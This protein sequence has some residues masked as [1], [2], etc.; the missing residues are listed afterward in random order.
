MLCSISVFFASLFIII[1]VILVSAVIIFLFQFPTFRG[2][3]G[4]QAV[5]RA[6]KRYL[7]PENYRIL[8][9]V[10]IC[11]DEGGSTQIDHIVIS[12]YGIFIIETKTMS[13]WIFGDEY[14]AKWMQQI[15]R[16]KNQFQNPL[17]QNYKHIACFSKL[18][19]VPMEG[20]FH[21]I[22]FL[23]TCELKTRDK[24]PASV[25]KGWTGPVKYIKSFKAE[26][27]YREDIPEI[28]AR[29]LAGKIENTHV[30]TR[31]HVKYVK[32]IVKEKNEPAQT[33][34][35]TDAPMCPRCGVPMILRTV[36]RGENK[37]QTFY[38]CPNYPKCRTIVKK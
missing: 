7:E 25:T 2:W 4:E 17:R 31:A 37:G 19:K 8:N 28:E 3:F 29:I 32:Q 27:L 35:D 16:Y 21:V 26:I 10:M 12:P 20:I 34:M 11:D 5:A 36:K 30:N 33:Q 22:A 38:G 13:G 15:Y 18:V 6:L 14:S 1:P 23:G 24:L 9:N